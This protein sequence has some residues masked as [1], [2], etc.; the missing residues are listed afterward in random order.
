M[1]VNP[2]TLDSFWL[3]GDS[4]ITPME[5]IDF[6]K[7]LYSNEL[8][9]SQRSMDIVKSMLVLEDREGYILRGKT[10][11]ATDGDYNVGW[12]VGWIEREGKPYFFATN[13]E[14]TKPDEA[15][16]IQSRTEITKA[17]LKEMGLY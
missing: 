5:Q 13:V 1:E 4:N 9:V 6:L 7:R 10:G 12:F 17:I 14:A 3:R 8:E 16:F 15:K 2:E 11:W